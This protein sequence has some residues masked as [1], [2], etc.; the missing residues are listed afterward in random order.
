MDA[1]VPAV[2]QQAQHLVRHSAHADLQRRAVLDDRCNVGSDVDRD[3]LAW[4]M[5]EL[6]ER[7]FRLRQHVDPV[8]VDQAVAVGARHGRVHL[9]NDPFRRT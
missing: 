2:T 3:L 9:G 6:A 1:K 7:A 5:G 4:R 8:E